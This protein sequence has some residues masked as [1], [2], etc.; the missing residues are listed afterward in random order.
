[1]AKKQS[2]KEI[3]DEQNRERINRMVDTIQEV[4]EKKK[5]ENERLYCFKIRKLE[6]YETP[7]RIEC[8]EDNFYNLD[9]VIYSLLVPEKK[10]KTV[11]YA[12]CGPFEKGEIPKLDIF[13]L[14][15]PP[16]LY[17]KMTHMYTNVILFGWVEDDLYKLLEFNST[18]CPSGGCDGDSIHQL[19]GVNPEDALGL[20]HF[21]KL[22]KDDKKRIINAFENLPNK[23]RIIARTK[24]VKEEMMAWFW[25][26]D[27]YDKWAF[28][29]EP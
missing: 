4:Q 19:V 24:A 23:N 20:M 17:L 10:C 22:H 21:I 25:H 15:K 1:M 5:E 29:D 26:P 8:L 27:R 9:R 11:R 12:D 16:Y 14:V 18:H 2:L 28:D 7:K 3:M 13:D 6:T